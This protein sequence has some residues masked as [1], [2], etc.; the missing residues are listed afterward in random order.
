VSDAIALCFLPS[1]KDKLERIATMRAGLSVPAESLA[2]RSH[3]HP[4]DTA[5]FYHLSRTLGMR[6]ITAV[7]LRSVSLNSNTTA[8]LI[9]YMDVVIEVVTFRGLRQI[10]KKWEHSLDGKLGGG[11]PHDRAKECKKFKKTRRMGGGLMN[12]NSGPRSRWK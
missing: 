6:D 7:W 3:Q 2:A 9:G 5:T 4:P 1:A 8:F 11:T 10:R 12:Q